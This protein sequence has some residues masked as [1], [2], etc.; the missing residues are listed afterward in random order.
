MVRGPDELEKIINEVIAELGR[1]LRISTAVLF[2]S[3]AR[4]EAGP[5]SDI[6]IAVFSADVEDWSA[7]KRIDLAVDIKLRYP[8]VELHLFSLDA[9][10]NARPSN[11][12]GHI[13]ETGKRVA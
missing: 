8:D 9:L 5:Y 2:G 1:G 3:Y 6:D 11:F 10:Q 4:D 13:L 7:E 12:Y